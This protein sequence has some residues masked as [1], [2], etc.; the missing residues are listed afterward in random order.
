M[1]TQL[2]AV[3]CYALLLCHPSGAVEGGEEQVMLW[4]FR[5]LGLWRFRLQVPFAGSWHVPAVGEWQYHSL[6]F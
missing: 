5:A 4:G 6:P 2:R 1:V 3:L